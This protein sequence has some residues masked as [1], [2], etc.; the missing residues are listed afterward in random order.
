MI[1]Q[2]EKGKNTVN[3]KVV[4]RPTNL[5]I[6]EM[7]ARMPTRMV[8]GRRT[9]TRGSSSSSL[10]STI[11]SAW[12]IEGDYGGNGFQWYPTIGPLVHKSWFKFSDCDGD[13]Y[14]HR[15]VVVVKVA[16]RHRGLVGRLR[17]CRCSHLVK[18]L[19]CVLFKA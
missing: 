17:S 6:T 16:L 15:V 13:D 5:L 10:F 18:V 3:N 9:R 19:V 1:I 14:L 7:R 4:A 12:A 2:I 11:G 8:M